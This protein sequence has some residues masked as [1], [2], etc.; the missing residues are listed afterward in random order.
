MIEPVNRLLNLRPGDLRRGWPFFTYLFLVIASYVMGQAYSNGLFL[1][2]FKADQLPYVDM[3]IA[4]LVGVI[5]SLYLRA[6]RRTGL[7]NLLI[8]C[9]LF[10]SIC[11]FGFWW[12]VHYT[13]WLWI[14]PVL[15]VSVGIFGVL[16]PMQL[17][18]LANFA[19]TTR[20]AKRLFALLGS[21]AILGG[22][23]GGWLAKFTPSR[24]GADALLLISAVFILLCV[25]LVIVIWRQ[26][27][28]GESEM[29]EVPGMA[30]Q[31]SLRQ[32]L[33]AI[34]GSSLLKTIAVLICIASV[35]AS[36][37]GWQFKA[38]A[39]SSYSDVN[40]YTA[41]YGQVTFYTGILALLAQALLTSKILRYFGI[42]VALF[43][44]PFAFV[45]GSAGL[46]LFNSLAA[47]T[48]LRASDKVF[49]YSVDKSAMELLY[50]PVRSEVKLQAKS[51]IDTVVWRFGDGLAGF[52]VL[53]FTR[54]P[55]ARGSSGG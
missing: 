10:L 3:T 46:L 31:R 45:A 27:E 15:Y 47:V 4:A 9:L 14:V 55:S 7:K 8:L 36:V 34:R 51:F 49:R 44:L 53:I 33:E 5:V 17:W 24:Y 39:K 6:S 30:Q 35:T 52:T 11:A 12:S 19:W 42:G 40:A 37:A 38:I 54:W 41:F 16:A 43:V 13:H 23:F 29:T 18:T 25:G 28:A 32:G 22:I 1:K 2:Q 20:E 48:F 26:R 50:L 21:G